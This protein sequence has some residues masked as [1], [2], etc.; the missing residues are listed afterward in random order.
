M[1]F[2]QKEMK[3]RVSTCKMR[4]LFCGKPVNN[5]LE[6]VLGGAALLNSFTQNR[7]NDLLLVRQ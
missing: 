7:Q 3:T 6:L 5:I 1:F 4:F 2:S